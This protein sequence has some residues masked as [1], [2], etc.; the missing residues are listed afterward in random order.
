VA[1]LGLAFGTTGVVSIPTATLISAYRLVLFVGAGV[2]VL[3]ALI[4][5]L[6]VRRN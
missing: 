1:A 3:G 2:A 4:A 6:T 5:A